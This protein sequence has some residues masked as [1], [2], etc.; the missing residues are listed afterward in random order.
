[1][2]HQAALT[3]PGDDRRLVL[4]GLFGNAVRMGTRELKLLRLTAVAAAGLA[5]LPASAQ[6]D[7]ALRS[8]SISAADYPTAALRAEEGGVVMMRLTIDTRGRVSNCEVTQSSG[9]ASVDEGSCKFWSRRMRYTPARNAAGHPVE[10]VAYQQL[11][12]I[13]GQRC[14]PMRADGI[15]VLLQ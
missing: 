5:A 9:F 8:G 14:P 1:M 7:P 10:G 6:T 13:I 3:G 4:P 11:G 2:G 15:C 12:W